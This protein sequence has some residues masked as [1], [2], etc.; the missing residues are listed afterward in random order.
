MPVLQSLLGSK[1]T[2]LG[3][4]T[5]PFHGGVPHARAQCICRRHDNVV[6][7]VC[8]LL[9]ETPEKLARLVSAFLRSVKSR[10]I[11]QSNFF[12]NEA[13]KS[14]GLQRNT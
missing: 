3:H 10:I 12:V 6:L 11:L 9:E 5:S 13:E 4:M 14:T 2:N 1:C 7:H 8:K